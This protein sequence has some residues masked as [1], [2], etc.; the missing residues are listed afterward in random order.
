M[1]RL[2]TLAAQPSSIWA[3]EPAWPTTAAMASSG[4]SRASPTPRPRPGFAA[5]CSIGPP[6]PG[7][8]GPA[9]AGP[10]SFQPTED[11][12]RDFLRGGVG[13]RLG[14]GEGALLVG[15]VHL[16]ERRLD[17][18]REPGFVPQDGSVEPV[19]HALPQGVQR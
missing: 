2:L 6:M 18:S 5:R 3:G 19:A 16:P 9:T 13:R 1:R 8:A 11:R 12:K 4:S 10:R 14:L 15:L 7:S 17:P